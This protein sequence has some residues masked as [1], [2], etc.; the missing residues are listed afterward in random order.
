MLYPYGIYLSTFVASETQDTIED[1]REHAV[2]CGAVRRGGAL[3]KGAA[4]RAPGMIY[5]DRP[6]IALRIIRNTTGSFV[7]PS[8]SVRRHSIPGSVCMDT[9]GSKDPIVPD[10]Y[11]LVGPARFRWMDRQR[12]R[13]RESERGRKEH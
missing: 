3:S 8:G 13:A 2:R 11:S 9:N 1:K 10:T 5:R 6:N 4:A 7:E 12:G